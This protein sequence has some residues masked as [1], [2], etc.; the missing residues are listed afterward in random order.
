MTLIL[1]LMLIAVVVIG[2]AIVAV[3]LLTRGRSKLLDKEN[4]RTA[5]LKIE[6][7]LDKNNAATYQFAILSADKLLDQA[8][9]ELGVAG[10]TTTD[11]LKNAKGQLSNASVVLTARKLRD[12]IAHETGAKINIIGARRALVAYKKALRELG[13]I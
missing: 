12:R 1:V 8:L 10:D 9:T 13:A 11:R 4:Y 3:M 6:N 7:N 5:W 2:A